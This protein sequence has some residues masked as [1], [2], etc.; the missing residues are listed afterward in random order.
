MKINQFEFIT[1]MIYFYS[2][3]FW[4]QLC[5]FSTQRNSQILWG[6]NCVS[7]NFYSDTDYMEFT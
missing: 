6:N 4:H 2:Q 1:T 5:G 7:Y 3:H